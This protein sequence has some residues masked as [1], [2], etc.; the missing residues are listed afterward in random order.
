MMVGTLA[1]QFWVLIALAMAA[2]DLRSGHVLSL[3][4]MFQKRYKES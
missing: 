1:V 2:S 3:A 4:A